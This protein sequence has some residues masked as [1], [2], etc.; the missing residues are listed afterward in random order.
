MIGTIVKEMKWVMRTNQ[1]TGTKGKSCHGKKI[2]PKMSKDRGIR[3]SVREKMINHNRKG[4]C[5]EKS[6]ILT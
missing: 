2:S 4:L 3:H 5:D 1:S 6:M